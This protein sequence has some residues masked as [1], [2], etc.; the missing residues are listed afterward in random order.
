VDGAQR[1]KATDYRHQMRTW[2]SLA[3]IDNIEKTVAAAAAA[4]AAA[5]AEVV[6]QRRGEERGPFKK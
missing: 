6:E 5:V 1:R 3:D 4:A 2:V